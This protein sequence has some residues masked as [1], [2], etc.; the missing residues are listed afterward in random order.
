MNTYRIIRSRIIKELEALDMIEGELK[1]NN[2]YPKINTDNYK[3]LPLSDTAIVVWLSNAVIDYYMCIERILMIIAKNI[4]NLVPSGSMWHVELLRQMACENIGVRPIVIS[5]STLELLDE[6]RGFRHV[7]RNIYGFNIHRN[8]VY[9]NLKKLSKV[10]KKF[11]KDI[12]QFL[13]LM[14]KLYEI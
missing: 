4:D 7:V 8:K 10:S 5:S 1:E 11:R 9:D 3:G 14:D 13:S 2:L 6:L 12:S